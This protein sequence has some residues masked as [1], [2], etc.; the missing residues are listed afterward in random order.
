M[1]SFQLTVS[2]TKAMVFYR[3]PGGITQIFEWDSYFPLPTTFRKPKP[4]PQPIPEPP[5]TLPPAPPAP[6]PVPSTS[7]PE[8][9][10]HDHD[11]G[12]YEHHDHHDH[13]FT[14]GDPI[15]WSHDHPGEVWVP[16]GGWASGP[17][18]PFG[19]PIDALKSA[20]PM[21]MDDDDEAPKTPATNGTNS[22]S[23][24][25]RVSIKQLIKSNWVSINHEIQ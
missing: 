21:D 23:W 15:S 2:L 5:P 18:N 22:R 6:I 19:P 14:S 8:P 1:A 16:P 12:H 20:P 24:N 3:N 13:D 11:H 10:D 17:S 9:D 25:I 4:P 7:A